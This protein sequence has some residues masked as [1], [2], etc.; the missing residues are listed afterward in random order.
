MELVSAAEMR[1]LDRAAIEDCK[2]PSLR[3]MENAGKA[4]VQEMER[5]FGRLRG[6]TV[7]VVAGKGQNGGD[8][9]VVARILRQRGCRARVGLLWPA[10]MLT[11]DAAITLRKYKQAGGRTF[12][13]SG[14]ASVAS[15]VAT[16]LGES[17]VLID[18][19]FGTG[20]NAPIEGPVADVIQIMNKTKRRIVAVDIPSGLDADSGEILGTAVQAFMTVTFAR[21]KRGLFLGEGPNVAGIIRM[22][23]IGIPEELIARARISLKLLDAAVVRASL[24]DRK[25]AAHKGSFGH[26]GIIAGST[27]KTGAAAMAA[28]GALRSGAGLVTVAVPAGLN[29]VLE[30]KLLEAMTFPVADTPSHGF[31]KAAWESLIEFASAKTAVAIGPG[32]GREPETVGLVHD[33]VTEIKQPL[34]IDADGINALASYTHILRRAQAPVI[35]TPHPGEMARL[36]GTSAADVQKDRLGVA[37]RFAREFNVHVVL[38]GAGTIVAGPDGSLAV[39]PTGNPGMATGGTGDVLTG[40]IVGFLAQNVAPLEAAS[41][42]TFLHGMAGDIAAAR[43]GDIGMIARD[44]IDAIPEA[45]R[46]IQ[47]HPTRE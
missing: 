5:C 17:D 2:I 32:I 22:A 30:A 13:V 46:K 1:A 3:L 42:A 16:L 31:A 21:A 18:A 20:L 8:G 40:M 25:P 24:P 9:F 43:R 23:D 4:V 36:L 33:L 12:P 6:K 26:A 19:I 45:I 11:K 7:T 35:L 38:K 41:L 34:V 10:S 27:G 47:C 28:L 14:E 29:A 37:G 44:L 39:N 15:T